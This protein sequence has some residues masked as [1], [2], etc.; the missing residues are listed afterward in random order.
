[1]NLSPSELRP[2]IYLRKGPRQDSG[3]RHP[4]RAPQHVSA[5]WCCEKRRRLKWVWE[6]ARTATVIRSIGGFLGLD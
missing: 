3:L 1:M 2:Y 5:N 6:G 4:M